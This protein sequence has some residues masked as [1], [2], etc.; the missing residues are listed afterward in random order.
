[1]R[2]LLTTCTVLRSERVQRRHEETLN[3]QQSDIIA[4]CYSQVSRE[5]GV[6]HD[7]K[8]PPDAGRITSDCTTQ[9]RTL[10]ERHANDPD[11]LESLL[12]GTQRT[13]LLALY[14]RQHAEHMERIERRV[15]QELDKSAA[16]GAPKSTPLLKLRVIDANATAAATANRTTTALLSVW[17]PSEGL[18]G[19]LAEHRTIGCSK[20]T[21]AGRRNGDLQLTAG[22]RTQFEQLPD[23][24]AGCARAQQFGRI[25]LPI[26]RIGRADAATGEPF[27]AAFDELD[28]VGVIVHI[29]E[30]IARKFQPVY[31][32]APTDSG[33]DDDD[34]IALLC[35]N[36]WSGLQAFAFD[37][38]VRVGRVL[39]ARDLQW[40]SS[41]SGAARIPCVFATDI[42]RFTEQP[43]RMRWLDA[44]WRAAAA[45]MAVL[46]ERV[47]RRHGTAGEFVRKSGQRI[48]ALKGKRSAAI[49][50]AAPQQRQPLHVPKV[51]S[52]RTPARGEPQ[53]KQQQQLEG[54]HDRSAAGR[55]YRLGN[56]SR[57][58]SR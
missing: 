18:L 38:L 53:E 17:H 19:A 7:D 26:E 58:S 36:F 33:G 2:C 25:V 42:T 8:P 34:G 54:S 6:Q 24:A 46:E 40:R 56:S 55:K 15:R 45:A 11:A 20:V 47:K 23:S 43:D 3:A 5:L 22:R 29:G 27:R 4:K 30:A 12:S 50:P 10:L 1:M 52:P 9:L 14:Q 21:A 32:A 35:I 28:T 39:A 13:E 37:D 16:V 51:F 41:V 49:M 44:G 31:M 57:P 48:E